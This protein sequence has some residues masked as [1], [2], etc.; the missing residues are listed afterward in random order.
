MSKCVLFCHRMTLAY[1]Y[2]GF[3]W[4]LVPWWC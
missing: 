3:I 4:R 1:T 2:K